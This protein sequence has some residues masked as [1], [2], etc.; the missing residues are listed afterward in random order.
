MPGLLVRS[1]RR[2]DGAPNW[3][4]AVPL[5]GDLIRGRRGIEAERYRLYRVVSGAGSVPQVVLPPP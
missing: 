5:E 4:G 1:L 3:P 2:G